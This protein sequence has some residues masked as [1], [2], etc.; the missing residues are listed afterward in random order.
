[1]VGL[2]LG[3]YSWVI[4]A[5][6]FFF[7]GLILLSAQLLLSV[8]AGSP[9]PGLLAA[10]GLFLVTLVVG[11][12]SVAGW[13]MATVCSGISALVGL[14]ISGGLSLDGLQEPISE[15]RR[16]RVLSWAL[17]SAVGALLLGW[18]VLFST[19]PS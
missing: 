7:L 9:L 4:V 8:M 1:M 18:A 16:S 15:E 14:L 11:P 10:I 19:L 2:D 5:M 17:L 6:R 13:I 3:H 12:F